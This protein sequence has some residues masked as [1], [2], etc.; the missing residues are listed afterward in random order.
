MVGF[1]VRIKLLRLSSCKANSFVGSVAHIHAPA[2]KLISF[3]SSDATRAS[4]D[5][6]DDAFTKSYLINSCGLNP[7]LLSKKLNLKSADKPNAVLACLRNHGFGDTQI[8]NVVQKQPSVLLSDP[9]KTLIPKLQLLASL[10]A[11]PAVVAKIIEK[12]PTILQMSLNRKLVP[13]FLYLKSLLGTDKNVVQAL[14]RCAWLLRSKVE[15]SIAPNIGVLRQLGMPEHVIIQC[16]RLRPA[17]LFLSAARF[18]EVVEQAKEMGFDPKH[19]IFIA[20]LSAL[21]QNSKETW[22]KKSQT[23]RKWGWSDTELLNAFTKGP[24]FIS[25]SKKKIDE[26]M[27]LMVNTMGFSPSSVAECPWIIYCSVKKL[28]ARCSVIQILEANGV[29]KR[30]DYKISALTIGESQ[31]LK[32][33]VTRHEDILPELLDVYCKALKDG[34]LFQVCHPIRAA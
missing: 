4:S 15:T 33:F 22:E 6:E 31:F 29:I 23:F 2:S 10:G 5:D 24:Q 26:V 12:S 14:L 16:L 7:N 20:A 11:S 25:F 1:V 21:A 17:T 3:F 34:K 19:S 13:S 27:D 9:E 32:R 30:A 8:A 18:K 28:T